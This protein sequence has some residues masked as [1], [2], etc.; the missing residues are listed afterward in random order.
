MTID[1]KSEIG[2]ALERKRDPESHVERDPGTF[3]ASQIG[4]CKRQAYL[5]KL[6]LKTHD[7]N[8]LGA[9][10]VG[11]VWH[12]WLENHLGPELPHVDFEVPVRF[13]DATITWVGHADAYDRENGVLY[14][15][16]TRSDFYSS[17]GEFRYFSPPVD[18]HLDQ[19]HVYMR[20]LEVEDAHIVYLSKK[21]I[22]DLQVWPEDGIRFDWERYNGLNRKA[23]EIKTQVE[24]RGIP[25]VP[26]EIPFEKCGCWV[27][28]GEELEL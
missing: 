21:N 1:W 23:R 9:F 28:D 25:T 17:D 15:F 3:H 12:E 7:V 10:E 27:C 5:S 16:K 11:T 4:Y 18:R 22:T 19:L 6:G 20:S 26:E 24:E 2:A 8:T 14:D 13:E